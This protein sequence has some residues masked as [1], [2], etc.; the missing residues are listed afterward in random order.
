MTTRQV[1]AL[2]G[3]AASAVA[4]VIAATSHT[5]GGGVA[6]A[7]WLVLA[8]ALLAWPVAV[9]LVGRRPSLV[10]I[11]TA[12]AAAQALLHVAFAAVGSADPRAAAPAAHGGHLS[13]GAGLM[14]GAWDV[15]AVV[16]A[17]PA[18][19]AAHALAAVLTAALLARGEAVL[20]AVL[21]GIRRL[22]DRRAPALPSPTRPPTRTVPMPRLAASVVLLSP[23]SRR[24][25]PALAR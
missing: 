21:R 17:D 22:L 18:M 25:P 12:V 16:H 11:G 2:R 3:A 1:R 5:I 10:R 14:A 7:P 13:H 15:P 6:P 19:L 23:L 4:V 8:V 24:G 20:R 9:L